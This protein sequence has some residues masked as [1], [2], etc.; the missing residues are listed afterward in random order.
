MDFEA[1]S[2]AKDAEQSDRGMS[3]KIAVVALNPE[4]IAEQAHIFRNAW[5][6]VCHESELPEPYDFRTASIGSENIIICRAP[7]GKINALLNVCPHRGMLIERRPQGSFLEGQASGNPKRITCMFHAWQFDM[8]G[9]CVYVAR[10]KE[11][12]QERFSKDDAGLRRLRC[13]VNFGG[14]V[15]VNMTDQPVAMLEEW[16]GPAMQ[17]IEN[18]ISAVPLEVVHYHKEYV[19]TGYQAEALQYLNAAKA[20]SLFDYGHCVITGSDLGSEKQ[21]SSARFPDPKSQRVT[22]VHLFPGYRFELSGP[23]L[24]VSVVTPVDRNRIMI[25][26]RGLVPQTESQADRE[27]RSKYYNLSHGPFKTP[28]TVSGEQ[29]EKSLLSEHYLEEWS[30]WMG[31]HPEGLS[32]INEKSVADQDSDQE[33]NK[34]LTGPHIVVIGASHA[35]IS[36]ADR[37]RKNGFIGNISIFDRQVGGPM[38]RPPLSKGFLLGGGETVESKSL[39]RQ[40]KWYKANK[41]KLKTQSVVHKIN[42]DNKTITVNNGDVVKY[43]KLVIA[44]GAVPKELPSSKGIGNAFV[45]R[46]PADANAIRQA[47]NNS[48]SVVIIGGGYI[49][50]EVAASLRKKGMDITVIE[51]GERILARVA[52][53]PLAEYLNK[54]HEDNGVTVI[55]NVGVEGINQEAGIFNNVTL[56]DG[57]VIKGDMLITGI[58]VYPDSQLASDAGLE[59]QFDNGGAILVDNDMR[60]SDEDIFAIGDVAIRREQTIAVES[61]HNAQETAAIAA[62]SITGAN[63][64]NTQT[65]WFWSDQYDAKLQSVGIVPVQ[66]ES[67]YQVERLGKREGAVSFWSYRGDELVAVEVVNDPATYMEARQCLD[68]RRFPDPKQIG[69]PSYSPVDSGGSRS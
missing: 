63:R 42:R 55:T 9:N 35:G 67:V 37:L 27:M 57:R 11:G 39:L 65:P 41:V 44:S 58:G 33:T 3:E 49:G 66:D 31:T 46:Q 13:T 61:V 52:S 22:C 1:I 60:T 47:A 30:M 25:E 40:K 24:N 5:V 18:Q 50:L 68:T 10:E 7:D 59:T 28:T 17:T 69:K 14:F 12:Y 29:S 56:S 38:E 48:D 2:D 21:D 15:W 32:R 16:A 4:F 54:L 20:G 8:R 53:K 34:I 26:H 36:M 45:L 43:D 23:V 6:P 51:A 64:P 62:A 19:E